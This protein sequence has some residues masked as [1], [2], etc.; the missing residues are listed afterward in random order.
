MLE[1]PLLAKTL[2]NLGQLLNRLGRRA[3]AQKMLTEAVEL[4]TQREGADHPET[5]GIMNNLA[6]TLQATGHQKRAEDVEIVDAKNNT[7]DVCGSHRKSIG[8]CCSPSLAAPEEP[9]HCHQEHQQED[10]GHNLH[11]HEEL[12]RNFQA[13]DPIDGF[14][15]RW[16]TIRRR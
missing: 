4:S 8:E 6:T 10:C 13:A 16:G 3:E 11:C 7:R 12:I 14:E 1:H 15:R 5:L 2:N 9:R